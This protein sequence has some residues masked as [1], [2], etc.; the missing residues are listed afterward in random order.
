MM[1]WDRP[2]SSD[3][4]GAGRTHKPRLAMLGAGG[5]MVLAIAGAVA[6]IVAAQQPAQA[7]RSI[8]VISASAPVLSVVDLSVSPAIKP[9]PDGQLH[10][11]FSVT[12]FHVRVGQPVK[13]VINNT[14]T[15][16]HSIIAPAVGVSIIARP[17]RHSYTLLVKKPGRFLWHC[18]YPCD[19]WSMQ[20]I[21]Y[22]RGYITAT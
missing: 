8:V 2:V 20:H 10:D 16:D 15:M 5:A 13:L 12:D 7:K 19:P 11:A 9:G 18:T 14:D 17:G 1:S 22:M 21:G 4:D 6:L 3:R